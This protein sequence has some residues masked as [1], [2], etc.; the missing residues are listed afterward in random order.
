MLKID[1]IYIF[2]LSKDQENFQRIE[3]A[4]LV[5]CFLADSKVLG[6]NPGTGNLI[7]KFTCLFWVLIHSLKGMLTLYKALLVDAS[8]C[9]VLI[10]NVEPNGGRSHS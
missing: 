7:E 1:K 2:V 8:D 10:N 4:Q 9:D 6:M 3:I 5:A